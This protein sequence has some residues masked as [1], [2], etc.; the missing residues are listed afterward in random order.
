M[1]DSRGGLSLPGTL[2]P[3]QSQTKIRR[4]DGEKAGPAKFLPR[5]LL[6]NNINV[7]EAGEPARQV[8]EERAA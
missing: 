7:V 3:E 1:T 2:V 6:Y 4:G 5:G 8:V